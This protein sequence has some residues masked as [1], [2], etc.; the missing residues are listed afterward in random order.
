MSNFSRF[1]KNNEELVFVI[2][3]RGK[4]IG[5]YLII[6]ILFPLLFFLLYPMGSQGRQG[7]FLWLGF[8]LLL[9]ILTMRQ[10]LKE[11]DCYLLTNQRIIHLGFQSK[12]K[13]IKKAQIKL[14][15]I[16]TIKKHSQHDLCLVS[17]QGKF[18]LTNIK[19]RRRVYNLIKL[20]K[21]GII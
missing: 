21:S 1:L 5:F 8:A 13:Y 19:E 18:Y 12:Q 16:Q 20:K 10:V 15:S 17:S 2:Q 7:F 6:F 14:K 3:K 11:Q 9:I 4:N